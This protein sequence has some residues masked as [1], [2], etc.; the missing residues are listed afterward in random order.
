VADLRAATPSAAAEAAV[1]DRRD[2]LRMVD[3]LATRLGSGLALRTSLA[4]ERLERTADRMTCAIRD[5]IGA[6]RNR[7][8]RLGAEL[9]ALSPLRVLQ[10][11]YAVP[12]AEG[13]VLKRAAEFIP[14]LAFELRIADGMIP[15]RVEA[16]D[17]S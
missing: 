4:A 9:N 14:G 10:R 12:S 5:M 13:R 17:G 2:V 8:D 11:G 15:A 7:T 1:A 3:D 16:R 6:R